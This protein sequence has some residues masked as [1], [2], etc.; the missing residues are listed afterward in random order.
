MHNKVAKREGKMAKV[1]HQI[2]FGLYLL[3]EIVIIILYSQCA[4]YSS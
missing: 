2:N 1:G 4:E 3:M